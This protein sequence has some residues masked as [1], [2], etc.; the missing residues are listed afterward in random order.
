[1]TKVKILIAVLVL[2]GIATGGGYWYFGAHRTAAGALNLYGNVDIRQVALAFNV[3]ERITEMYVE[4]G[5]RVKKGQV[6]AVLDTRRFNNRVAQSAAQV[7][8]QEQV[9]AALVAGSR[10]EEIHQARASAQAARV[11]AHNARVTAKR[12]SDLRKRGLT[13]KENADDARAAADA[14]AARLSAAEAALELVVKGPRKEDIAAAK[15]G[16]RALHAQLALNREDLA[17]ARLTAPSDGIIEDRILQP[18]DMATPQTPVFTLSLTQPLWVRAYVE[19][20]DLGKIYPGMQATVT[21]DSFPGKHYKGWVGFISPTAEFTPKNVETP[22]MRTNLVY[23]VRVFVCNPDNEL[24]QG[25]PASVTLPLRRSP[26][27]VPGCGSA[28]NKT[29]SSTPVTPAP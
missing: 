28:G 14:A 25:M 17:D 7:A 3:A 4:E 13:S 22:D 15:A 16:L 26:G 24:R 8:A 1:M 9:V 2:A 6:L 19:E 12:Q 29:S 18:G 21:T 27:F 11:Q 20:S 23:Q 5:D 10:P